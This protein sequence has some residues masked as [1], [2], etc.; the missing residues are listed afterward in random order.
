MYCLV[1]QRL[2]AGEGVSGSSV[3]QYASSQTMWNGNG[4]NPASNWRFSL[5]ELSAS[6]S[7]VDSAHVIDTCIN[8]YILS[9]MACAVSTK[10]VLLIL[11]LSSIRKA[12]WLLNLKSNYIYSPQSPF[13]WFCAV[14]LVSNSDT[15]RVQSQV[16]DGMPDNES[17]CST[18]SHKRCST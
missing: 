3:Q 17:S 7:Y 15:I 18:A 2:R 1:W 9:T 16:F 12:S 10:K 11:V 14:R 5:D 6:E 8:L 13:G 4:R